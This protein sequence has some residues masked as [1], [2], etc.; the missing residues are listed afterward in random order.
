MWQK[1]IGL[2]LAQLFKLLDPETIKDFVDA[3]LDKLEEKFIQGE[4]D[5]NKEAAVRGGIDFIRKMMNIED[6]EYGTDK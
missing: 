4:V 5:T 2:A 3:G 6:K 1:L